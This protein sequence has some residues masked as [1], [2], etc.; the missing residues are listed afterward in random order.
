MADW[1]D[2]FQ[3]YGAGGGNAV[4]TINPTG[5]WTDKFQPYDASGYD[6][7]LESA[8][9]PED[10]M[11]ADFGYGS[12]FGLAGQ[13][14]S[15]DANMPAPDQ[16]QAYPDAD[17][18][19]AFDDYMQRVGEVAAPTAPAADNYPP[20]YSD[21]SQLSQQGLIQDAQQQRKQSDKDNPASAW[22]S[23][24]ADRSIPFVSSTM[25]L[26]DDW[27]V[28]GAVNDLNAGR[29]LNAEQTQLMAKYLNEQEAE[30]ERG[31]L[32]KT[33]NIV[34]QLPAFAGELGIGKGAGVAARSTARAMISAGLK[35]FLEKSATGAA[36]RTAAGL[37]RRGV[38]RA[39]ELATRTALIPQFVAKKTLER[40]IQN[41]DESLARSAAHGTFQ[42]G[43]EVATELIGGPLLKSIFGKPL[44]DIAAKLAS[45]TTGLNPLRL[46]IAGVWINLKPGRDL[47]AFVRKTA[48]RVG[49]DGVLSE[50]G[51]ERISDLVMGLAGEA[52]A[53]GSE[54]ADFGTLGDLTEGVAGLPGILD[55]S[56]E[57]SRISKKDFNDE[58]LTSDEQRSLDLAKQRSRG[59]KGLKQIA[60]EGLAFSA[61]PGGVAAVSGTA[62]ALGLTKKPSLTP[63][64]AE[65]WADANPQAAAKLAETLA[66]E[67]AI[68]RPAFDAAGLPTK[69]SAG[70]RKAFAEA[71]AT[72]LQQQQQADTSAGDAG[73]A[74]A[75]NV[76]ENTGNSPNG[77]GDVV[78]NAGDVAEADLTFE[79]FER[80]TRAVN[81]AAS[82]NESGEV[83]SSKGGN[84]NASDSNAGQKANEV[85]GLRQNEMQV[86]LLS[87]NDNAGA[88]DTPSGPELTAPAESSRPQKPAEARVPPASSPPT[89]AQPAAATGGAVASPAQESPPASGE[90]S[91]LS[92]PQF[93]ETAIPDG[94]RLADQHGGTATISTKKDVASIVDWHSVPFAQRFTE[95]EQN[96]KGRGFAR[97]VIEHLNGKGITQF[98]INLQSAD[99]RKVMAR[100]IEDGT[101]SPVEGFE[102]GGSF[103]THPTRFAI[104]RPEGSPVAERDLTESNDVDGPV[105]AWLR[106]NATTIAATHEASGVADK[107]EELARQRMTAG[108]IAKKLGIS[109]E[110]VL[111]VRYARGIPSMTIGSGGAQSANPEFETWLSASPVADSSDD[112]EIQDKKNNGTGGPE[113]QYG[114]KT[115]ITTEGRKP[116]DAAFAVVELESLQ[117][118]SRFT[119]GYP[120]SNANYPK[121]LQPR[122]YGPNSDNTEKVRRHANPAVYDPRFVLADSAD[123][124]GGSPTVTKSGV[125]LNGNGRV[126]T[127]E[128]IRFHDAATPHP[129][130]KSYRD[131]LAKLA[132]H[133][134]IDPA[135]VSSMR[136]PV[137]VRVVDMD[138]NSE[139]ARKFAESGNIDSTQAQAPAEVARKLAAVMNVDIVAKVDVTS[140]EATFGEAINGQTSGAKA[141][142]EAFAAAIPHSQRAMYVES[143]GALTEAGKELVQRILSQRLLSLQDYESLTKSQQNLLDAAIPQL[144]K[145]QRDHDVDVIPALLE[146][147]N[148]INEYGIKS[149]AHIK[150]ALNQNRVFGEKAKLSPN[151]RMAIDFL[152]MSEGKSTGL[153]TAM[154]SLLSNLDPVVGNALFEPEPDTTSAT[155]K[156]AHAFKVEIRD[157]ADF[158]KQGAKNE[159]NQQSG[160]R[161]AGSEIAGEAGGGNAGVEGRF[162]EKRSEVASDVASSQREVD[163][164]RKTAT[165]ADEALL[166]KAQNAINEVLSDEWRLR[167]RVNGNEERF[168]PVSDL[169][170]SSPLV[171]SDA[172]ET[173][174]AKRQS[175]I[176]AERK[177]LAKKK[178]KGSRKGGSS[179]KGNRRDQAGADAANDSAVDRAAIAEQVASLP[180]DEDTKDI[181]SWH[182]RMLVAE[183]KLSAKAARDGE[184]A[185]VRKARKR[186]EEE[187]SAL[188]QQL[189]SSEDVAADVSPPTETAK[190]AKS[191]D[192][193]FGERKPRAAKERS[194]PAKV[195]QQ[196]LV[197]L[198]SDPANY[199]EIAKTRGANGKPIG[200]EGA[201]DLFLLLADPE[202]VAA[203]PSLLSYDPAQPFVPWAVRL[204]QNLGADDAKKQART[205]LVGSETL[206]R[207]PAKK[208]LQK[209]D[210]LSKRAAKSRSEV[211]DALDDFGD[212]LRG[213]A[214]ATGS[215]SPEALK[216][217]AKLSAAIV[218]AGA[219]TFADYTARLATLLTPS[220]FATWVPQMQSAFDAAMAEQSQSKPQLS[221]KAADEEFDDKPVAIPEPADESSKP[222]RKERSPDDPPTTGT[223][224]AKMEEML[225][226]HGLEPLL[227]YDAESV[228]GWLADAT[229]QS[230]DS[231]WITGLIAELGA[232]PRPITAV[233]ELGLNLHGAKIDAKL[234]EAEKAQV[235]AAKS[236]NDVAIV[237]ANAEV[238]MVSSELYELSRITKAVGTLWGRAG[239]ARQ[240]ELESDF[241]PTGLTRKTTI[242][243]G[244]VPPTAAEK[245]ANDELAARYAESQKT[246]AELQA[247]EE[248]L[249]RQLEYERSHKEVQEEVAKDGVSPGRKAAKKR[250]ES[251][252]AKWKRTLRQQGMPGRTNTFGLG[253]DLFNDSV[254]VAKAYIALGVVTFKDFSRKMAKDAGQDISAYTD[255]LKKAW[256]EALKTNPIDQR[257]ISSMIDKEDPNNVAAIAKMLQRAF[258]ESGMTARA[259]V[260]AA[261]HAELAKYVPDITSDATMDAMS[262]YGKYSTL[263]REAVDSKIRELNGQ[264]QQLAKLRDMQAGHAPLMTGQERREVGDEERL[265][266][267]QVNELK[268]KSGFAL[269]AAKKAISNRIKDLQKE[270]DERTRNVKVRTDVTP[271][272]ELIA[273]R[274][275]RD[276]LRAKHKEIFG[277]RELTDAQRI[278]MAEKAL[279]RAIMGLESDL[280]KNQLYPDKTGKK[281]GWS[282]AIAAKHAHLDAL[283]AQRQELRDIANPKM[284]EEERSNA[285]YGRAILKQIAD[286][287][288]RIADGNFGPKAKPAPRK[289]SPELLTAL[290]ERDAVRSKFAKLQR[291]WQKS[292]QHWVMRNVVGPAVDVAAG[293]RAFWT[294]LDASLIRRQGGFLFAAHPVMSAKLVPRYFAS[295]PL[296][297]KSIFATA[298]DEIQAQSEV[299]SNPN[300]ETYKSWGVEFTS[301]TADDSSREEGMNS[302]LAHDYIPGVAGS[303]RGG[304]NFLNLQ[305]IGQMDL[306]VEGLG[307]GT[308]ITDADGRL[309]AN[310]VNGATGR[311]DLGLKKWKT[312]AAALAEV[313]LAPRWRVSRFNM[314]LGQPLR[315]GL[316]APKG[317][318]PSAAARLIIAKEY[319]RSI[320]GT[321]AYYGTIASVLYA[322]IGPPGPDK[323]WDIYWDTTGS[324]GLKIR[325]NNTYIDLTSGISQA[326]VF[327][328]KMW[329]G[330]TK[331]ANDVVAPIRGPQVPRGGTTAAGVIGKYIQGGLAPVPQSAFEIATGTDFLGQPITPWESITRRMMPMSV[332]EIWKIMH[333]QGIPA[334]VA[335]SMLALIGEGANVYVADRDLGKVALLAAQE[336]ST[337][338]KTPAIRGKNKGLLAS[339]YTAGA[340]DDAVILSARQVLK[341]RAPS[342]AEQEA[343]LDAAWRK[344]NDGKLTDG[345]HKAKN[346]LPGY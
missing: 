177:G 294:S 291:G 100:L 82:P 344:N 290:A 131:Q 192:A 204:A 149:E 300:Y 39:A 151:G 298:E 95:N 223:K 72:H 84:P 340:Q 275:E 61:V 129:G 240:T 198:I 234:I 195:T 229:E 112:S 120:T 273:L 17:A 147:M 286:Y 316:L 217:F 158:T 146:A 130:V 123:A 42:A 43:T 247:K 161:G 254:E 323:D 171:R 56:D 16:P 201:N 49:W 23:Y 325:I 133:F 239:R 280:K 141:F 67:G 178:S 261:V 164:L 157:G 331:K 190:E 173:D 197:D 40:Q 334:G 184:T 74:T 215:F 1:T 124:V 346:R 138:E 243:K 228:E 264:Y 213:G 332:G 165:P 24:I 321:A 136:N 50:I 21:T 292:R 180:R 27:V 58:T 169:P 137:L 276:E 227:K 53:S 102:R 119:D 170:K 328:T 70:Q 2:K 266:I 108:Q 319:A 282:P 193:A 8:Q 246:I 81:S 15:L 189:D 90:A 263:S 237:K 250:V 66:S 209:K 152:L 269:P 235:A 289:L 134:G 278:A 310:F 206:D 97:A 163:K 296:K 242:S 345:F 186:L 75:E 5:N 87:K 73:D 255:T 317:E 297:S 168:S 252:I 103:D 342:Y 181:Q 219:L 96:F 64:M 105:P 38:G 311:G 99:T 312:A 63:G 140:A 284:T 155:E 308:S 91:K 22:A 220:Q 33:G 144:L 109:R 238:A 160:V 47:A 179:D 51:E 224:N 174:D 32:A 148:F 54:Y 233:E 196:Q 288:Q 85:P 333:D 330:K 162:S 214:G 55:S 121:N 262:G 132:P 304:T 207:L 314:L 92:S 94:F 301:T 12:Q 183:S 313:F 232:N 117:P 36:T 13:E 113:F 231:S 309:F 329:R 46:A 322:V 3:R 145:M 187:F 199:D 270:I 287:R 166:L 210:S 128:L 271:D 65:E 172:K 285:A 218:K 251:A 126:M 176:P 156:V 111:A 307:G 188:R 115:K 30:N 19:A 62:K 293:I 80:M 257:D 106:H 299:E 324:T 335:I 244:G 315:K 343:L 338:D 25:T 211:L 248:E 10:A 37:A 175:Q 339:Q 194:E 150:D 31:F 86:P 159:E 202:R 78:D 258:V 28:L 116:V 114:K 226:K 260:L 265:L 267:A 249:Q 68:S 4:T 208:G 77:A 203:R 318:R 142:R 89:P 79:D 34:A 205:K 76:V 279:D 306:L 29:E 302:Q 127:E 122:D 200:E 191:R 139:E 20:A 14:D 185:A 283:R 143:D 135:A 245:A 274:A 71:V 222:P 88:V 104:T 320:S 153:R 341:S 118:S 236:G 9:S 216:G 59:I 93:T 7:S 336:L 125:V 182:A 253:A 295:S 26:A 35:K 110:E 326:A 98:D 272:A 167:G 48:S 83:D 212:T 154:K 11:P 259:D 69:T 225:A 44:S 230:K 337:E 60:S 277:N 305:R 45:K 327:L 6:D 268:K 256:D 57:I 52:G 221:T 281:S 101:V 107:V 303:E 241:T 18:Q 41:P